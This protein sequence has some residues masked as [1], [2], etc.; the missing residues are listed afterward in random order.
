MSSC[1]RLTAAAETSGAASERSTVAAIILYERFSAMDQVEWD[2]DLKTSF[3]I[4][5]RNEVGGERGNESD[6]HP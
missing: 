4:R 6:G 1:C 3:W 5:K 2:S